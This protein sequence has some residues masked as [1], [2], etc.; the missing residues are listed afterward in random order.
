MARRMNEPD[1]SALSFTQLDRARRWTFRFAFFAVVLLGSG[2]AL[3]IFMQKEAQERWRIP[4][5]LLMVGGALSCLACA[6]GF[7][8]QASFRCPR[9]HQFFFKGLGSA[10]DL[11]AMARTCQHCGLAR[12]VGDKTPG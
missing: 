5:G 7:I 8:R 2:F 3:T 1:T 9:C 10:S 11:Y 4:E 12:T 6:Y